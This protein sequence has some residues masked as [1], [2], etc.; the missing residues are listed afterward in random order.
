MRVQRCNIVTVASL[1]FHLHRA[2]ASLIA[3][4]IHGVFIFISY[5]YVFVMIVC[6]FVPNIDSSILIFISSRLVSGIFSVASYVLYCAVLSLPLSCQKRKYIMSYRTSLP[7]QT[8][9][10]Y[11]SLPDTSQSHTL[12]PSRPHSSPPSLGSHPRTRPNNPHDDQSHPTHNPVRQSPS[13]RL[14]PPHHLNLIE[15]IEARYSGIVCIDVVVC[16]AEH[17]HFWPFGD[18]QDGC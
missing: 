18:G 4:A 6:S 17:A 10:I 16:G 2:V 14:L 5:L 13:P 8:R 3:I 12:L 1:P 11:H 7:N 9:H 15:Q